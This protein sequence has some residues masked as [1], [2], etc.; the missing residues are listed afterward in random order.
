MK[1]LITGT[2]SGI[3]KG[4]AEFFLKENHEV[5]GFDKNI[6]SIQHP[7]YT[8]FC[9]DIRDKNSYPEIGPV[10]ILIN[11]AGYDND[12]LFLKMQ[13]EQWDSVLNVNLRSLFTYTQP[14]ASS[15]AEQRWGRIINLTSIAGFTGAF[16][17][18]NYAAAKAGIVGFTRSL[19]QELGG[20]GITVNAVA[21]GA[22]LTDMLM[23]IPEKYRG[24]ILRNIAAKRF[25]EPEEVA[26]LI[27][28]LSSDKATYINGQTI[29]INGGS[30]LH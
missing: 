25:G 27:E 5:Y 2:A 11:N 12:A 23:R 3:G 6:S 4:C 18:S 9:L 7:K 29:H 10:D 15:M 19:A 22:I 17:K 20:Q 14:F 26:D 8:H 1:V 16:G 24:D 30:F 28:F 13:S 21:P